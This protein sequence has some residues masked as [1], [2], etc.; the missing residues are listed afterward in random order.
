MSI[1]IFK[2]PR[3]LHWI[4]PRRTWGFS[5]SDNS[6]YLTFDDGP[7]PEITDWVL[8]FLKKHSIRATF[9]CVGNNL[10]KNSALAERIIA[11]GHI[12]GNHTMNHEKS[13]KVRFNEYL[14]SVEAADKLTSN[15]FFRP[16]YGRLSMLNSRML[17]KNYK[18]IMWTWLSYDFDRSVPLERIIQKAKKQIKSGDI[19]VLH[20]NIK[21]FDR[22]K[23]LLPELIKVIQSKGLSFELIDKKN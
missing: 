17:N 20:D 6:V 16:P 2:T 5:R 4:F 3:F 22:L 7:Q 19:I 11:E 15:S 12:I 10:V 14:K 23:V 21:T 8:D 18:I 9:F 13:T 1:K